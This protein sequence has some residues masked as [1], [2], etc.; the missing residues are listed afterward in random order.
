M[1]VSFQ[2]IYPFQRVNGQI[3]ILVLK[4]KKNHPLV[5]R[6]IS[7]SCLKRKCTSLT[8]CATRYE[9]SNRFDETLHFLG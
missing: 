6:S 9:P 2:K 3:V 8:I 7:G 1:A 4:Q 5:G